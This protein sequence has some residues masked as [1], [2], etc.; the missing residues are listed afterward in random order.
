MV[1]REIPPDRLGPSGGDALDDLL[2]LYVN[3]LS[4]DLRP[5]P[6]MVSFIKRLAIR[7]AEVLRPG[8]DRII[9]KAIRED[10]SLRQLC[11]EIDK[12]LLSDSAGA[13]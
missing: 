13:K 3:D 7:M 6:E 10:P 1:E 12:H 2:A 4:N 5:S 9:D 8:D 11:E